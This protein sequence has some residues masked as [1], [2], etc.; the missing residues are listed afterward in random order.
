MYI[1]GDSTVY[2]TTD[3][4][5][6]L[7]PL[8]TFSSEHIQ[9]IAVYNQTLFCVISGRLLY[10]CQDDANGF[11]V[12]ATP[13]ICDENTITH[14]G[15]GRDRPR[16]PSQH[17]SLNRFYVW[18]DGQSAG[19]YRTDDGGQDLDA[20]CRSA[21][22]PNG[23]PAFAL[24]VCETSDAC[25]SETS[26]PTTSA[27]RGTRCLRPQPRPRS[28]LSAGH[29]TGAALA[30][31][32]NSPSLVYFATDLA[33]G[34]WDM[35]TAKADEVHRA[36]GIEDVAIVDIAQI[37]TDAAT[38]TVIWAATNRGLGKTI[39]YPATA[40]GSDWLFPVRPQDDLT[41]LTRVALHPGDLDIVLAGDAGGTIYRTTNGGTT[42]SS[43]T[44]VFSTRNA[45][46]N[47][48]YASPEKAAVTAIKVGR[49]ELDHRLRGHR[50][51]RG[52]IRRSRLSQPEQRHDL[53]RRLCG[54]LRSQ[55]QHAG[56]RSD[57]SGQH[58][59][60][61]RRASAGHQVTSQGTLRPA[62]GHRRGQ[63]VEDADGHRTRSQA[64]LAVEGVKVGGLKIL[65]AATDQG[66]Y[67]GRLN[68]SV[69]SAWSWKAITP[70]G[71][72][73]YTA[74]AADP[75]NPN[76]V[77]VAY[78]N[79]IWSSAD[80]GHS[81]G[82]VPPSGTPECDQILALRQNDLLVGTASG[83]FASPDG[84]ANA[85]KP[86]RGTPAAAPTS[87]PATVVSAPQQQPTTDKDLLPFKIPTFFGL[88]IADTVGLWL[89]VLAWLAITRMN[90]SR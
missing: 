89:P 60:G 88:G 73:R 41:P 83:L 2:R 66:V 28:G 44:A 38:Q 48:R 19:L 81:W 50:R 72:H 27:K 8:A 86:I 52:Q 58:G 64:V 62:L 21:R 59:L 15:V 47:T 40:D 56:Q 1:G 6:T 11:V 46:F 90:R 32:P 65:Y 78:D 76:R 49:Q 14:P 13:L 43:W 30:G 85:R 82:L 77:F 18:S 39:T 3:G 45:P 22:Q 33:V 12:T 25:L 17:L 63:L 37:P 55:P 71:K 57:V 79:A 26:T 68:S 5:R 75:D 51:R 7:S 9:S 74:L 34:Q 24:P 67:C 84:A 87:Q 20:I 80:G 42:P 10:R 61:R 35:S 16:R 31:D 29:A 4:G 23:R 36:A 54:R 53:G 69:G 70:D